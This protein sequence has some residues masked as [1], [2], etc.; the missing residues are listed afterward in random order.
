VLSSLLSQ[1]CESGG[2]HAVA[3]LKLDDSD[4]QVLYHHK[5]DTS[6]HI[7]FINTFDTGITSSRLIM[8]TNFYD[9]FDSRF[10][11]PER[12][13]DDR[14]RQQK[15]LKKQN[16]QAQQQQQQQQQQ[17]Y[18]VNSY[19]TYHDDQEDYDDDYQESYDTPFASTTG[20]I[21]DAPVDNTDQLVEDETTK[22]YSF[23]G[24]IQ[25]YR[26]GG[27]RQLL[28]KYSSSS[29]SWCSNRRWRCMVISV[30]LGFTLFFLVP[31]ITGLL[32]NAFSKEEEEVP[33]YSSCQPGKI[34]TIKE[35]QLELVLAGF[36]RTTTELEQSELAKAVSMGY[37]AVSKGCEDVYERW[38]F[39]AVLV[40]QE[41]VNFSKPQEHGGGMTYQSAL[42]ATFSTRISCEG[43]S[44]GKAFASVYPSSFGQVSTK[45][46]DPSRRKL[47][48]LFDSPSRRRQSSNKG[49]SRRGSKRHRGQNGGV[50][51]RR[52]TYFGD[53]NTLVADAETQVD[54]VHGARTLYTE[55]NDNNSLLDAGK[56]LVAIEKNI[57][58]AGME[59]AK[60][61][62]ISNAAIIASTNSVSMEMST[63]KGK[64]GKSG[65]TPGATQVPDPSTQQPSAVGSKG[66]KGSKAG[67]TPGPT[68]DPTSTPS[69][70]PTTFPSSIPSKP[71]TSQPSSTPSLS[72]TQQCGSVGEPCCNGSAG[73]A[74]VRPPIT[75]DGCD[76]A[77]TPTS[78]NPVGCF[79]AAQICRRCGQPNGRCCREGVITADEEG[80]VFV[81]MDGCFDFNARGTVT[82]ACFA[83]GGSNSSPNRGRCRPCGG[84]DDRCCPPNNLFP[85]GE[86]LGATLAC[87]DTGTSDGFRCQQP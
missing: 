59:D 41:L 82:Y 17:K 27:P 45:E 16:Q 38:M 58:E 20:R 44:E 42:V 13:Y 78:G 37:N 51:E 2:N 86:C 9:E 12:F 32:S 1:V 34:K 28:I 73:P 10:H 77:T 23:T 48:L 33:N 64:G 56:I 6:L 65:G 4:F 87:L 49:S 3:D 74:D 35:P 83:G 75:Q 62:G 71:P 50:V 54:V 21:I 15:A 52:T 60:F 24:K 47:Q 79:G 61:V 31:L 14:R 36:D 43:C 53:D 29:S 26:Y 25:H 19:P 46:D 11:E 22:P 76:D 40:D 7:I 85:G 66:S 39:D 84:E 67:G 18:R 55:E 30:I 68:Q 72:P 69:A 81:F 70:V 63:G 8:E 5:T 57:H 80:D